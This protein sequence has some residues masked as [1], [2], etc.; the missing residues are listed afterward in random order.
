VRSQLQTPGLAL[1]DV[2]T[3]REWNGGHLPGAT[4][5]LWQD[6]FADQKTMKWKSPTELRAL[7]ERAGVKPGQQIVTYCAVGMRA[8]LMAWAAT[9]LGLPAQVYVGSW[10]DWS[11]NAANPVVK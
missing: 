10:Q 7:F 4:L 11:Q 8:S 9:S 1:L 5:I 2:R 3:T 6:L